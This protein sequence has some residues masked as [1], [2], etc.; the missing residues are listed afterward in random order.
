MF[1]ASFDYKAQGKIPNCDTQAFDDEVYHLQTHNRCTYKR[2]YTITK[3]LYDVRCVLPTYLAHAG[4]DVE[5]AMICANWFLDM[6]IYHVTNV[7]IQSK[8]HT[9]LD[10]G[11]NHGIYV[12]STPMLHSIEK[13]ICLVTDFL[14][15]A[16]DADSSVEFKI[17]STLEY[18]DTLSS[19]LRK[20]IKYNPFFDEQI[21]KR[22]KTKFK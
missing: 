11:K 21:Y 18:I 2:A 1:E 14:I 19:A 3:I 4:L 6:S 16:I 20:E 10:V 22:V 8:A 17:N 9:Y 15:E 12:L 7:F 13:V 5:S